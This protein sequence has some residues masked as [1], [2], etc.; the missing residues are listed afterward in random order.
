VSNSARDGLFS[1]LFGRGAVRVADLDWLQAML[2]TEAALARALETAG[3]AAAGGGAQVTAVARA[4]RF[5][6][7]ELGRQAMLT[8]NPVPALVR[9][10]TSLVPAEARQAVHRGA[11]SQDIIDTAAMLL[12]RR[13]IDVIDADLAAAANRA[14]ALADE[15]AATVM[16]G[17]TLLQQAVPVTFGLVAA[18][19]L[20]GID[21]A[22]ADL[23]S[24]R[25]RLAVQFGGAAGTL[26]SLGEAGPAVAALLAAEFGLP[27]PVLPW[28]TDR[29]RVVQL[30]AGLAGACAVLG[31]VARDVTLLAQTEVAELAE[32]PRQAGRGGSS[33][34]P[35]KQNPFASVVILGCTKRAPNLLATLVAAAEQEH[36]RA[37]GAWHAEWETLTDLLRLTGSAA[38]WAAELLTGLAVDAA[39]MQANLGAA[40]GLPMAENVATML[41]PVL[42]PGEAHDLVAAAAARG[43][44]QGIALPDALLADP[45][46]A[47]R[48]SAI[49]IG[50][51]ELQAAVDPTNYL[52]GSA[53][54]I[55]KALAAHRDGLMTS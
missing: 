54:F 21:D 45:N 16:A 12:S 37:A 48:L 8:G 32:G 11:T 18:G 42:G 33:A 22:R 4:E 1:G 55:R 5:D 38:S 14:A 13:A 27:E 50:R 44:A 39:R 34:M 36:Q 28:H 26:A 24:A 20:V 35:H 46:A 43:A 40:G 15:H 25:A 29:L 19:W 17:R 23:R 49:G 10:L 31:K 2:D 3:L 51:A 52:G 7:T 30:G 47:A 53:E 9:A 6:V 41:A